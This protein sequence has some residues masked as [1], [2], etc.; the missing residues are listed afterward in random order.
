M[1]DLGKRPAVLHILKNPAK[2]PATGKDWLWAIGYA[3]EAFDMLTPT[4]PGPIPP[5]VQLTTQAAYDKL[6]ADAKDG[7]VLNLGKGEFSVTI[8]K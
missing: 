4:A 3:A 1:I 2:Y 6:I 7:E 8:T 5:V